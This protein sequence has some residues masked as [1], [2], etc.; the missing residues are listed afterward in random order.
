MQTGVR[1]NRL[2][3][4]LD[5]PIEQSQKQAIVKRPAQIIVIHPIGMNHR[6]ELISALDKIS[7]LL[8]NPAGKATEEFPGRTLGRG[9]LGFSL[10]ACPRAIGKVAQGA[11]CPGALR[12]SCLR[13]GLVCVWQ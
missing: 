12:L 2:K 13:G 5:N 4:G 3:R 8:L 9:T 11:Q 7:E 1:D 6:G 10:E